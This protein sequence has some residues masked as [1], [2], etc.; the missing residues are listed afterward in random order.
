LGFLALAALPKR[1]PFASA[2]AAALFGW[3]GASHLLAAAT[4]FN[5]CPEP[6]A[7]PSLVLRREVAAECGPWEWLDARLRLA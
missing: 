3:F 7:V 1:S 5:G 2:P 4:A 6:G